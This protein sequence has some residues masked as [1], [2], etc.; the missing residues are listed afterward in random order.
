LELISIALLLLPG[1]GVGEK[2]TKKVTK[3]VTSDAMATY[4]A[5]SPTAADPQLL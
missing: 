5:S 4:G 1:D 3:E 2:E